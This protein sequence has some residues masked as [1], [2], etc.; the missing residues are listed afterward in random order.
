[1]ERGEERKGGKKETGNGRRTT[2]DMK[3]RGLAPR[4]E[5]LAAPQ[6]ASFASS[7]EYDERHPTSKSKDE[8]KQLNETVYKI[9]TA[10]DSS[11][12]GLSTAEA[13]P[14]APN[15]PRSSRPICHCDLVPQPAKYQHHTKLYLMLSPDIC[16]SLPG[17]RYFTHDSVYFG[18]TK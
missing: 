1:M 3:V 7:A 14:G 4:R 11:G 6:F 12:C 15:Q 13:D 5:I 8:Q 16:T 2:G 9:W 10:A 18:V 17:D